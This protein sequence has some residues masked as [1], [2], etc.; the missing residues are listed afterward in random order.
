M[1]SNQFLKIKNSFL[2]PEKDFMEL[3]DRELKD[4]EELFIRQLL[5]LKIVWIFGH[6]LNQKKKKKKEKKGSIIKE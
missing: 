5:C 6:F 2:E 1:L 4:G 3:K